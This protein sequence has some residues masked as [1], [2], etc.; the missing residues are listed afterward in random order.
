MKHIFLS[1]LMLTAFSVIPGTSMAQTSDRSKVV[2]K[3]GI[4]EGHERQRASVY[5]AG[6]WEQEIGYAQAIK[7]GNTIYVSGTVGANEKGFP[8]D[9]ES[10]MKLAYAAIQRT[11]AHY[12]ANLSN[13]VME[14]IQ[15]T[16]M[17]ALIKSQDARKRIYGDW[18]P[19]ATWIEVKRLYRTEA[20]IEIDVEVRLDK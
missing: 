8:D 15:T 11:L 5:H 18:L 19:A 3:T 4:A 1:L 7:V 10:Q 13:V 14:R 16:D 2:T 9:L 17:D 6:L 12:G 20:R